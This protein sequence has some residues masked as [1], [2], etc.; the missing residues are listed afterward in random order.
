[1][2]AMVVKQWLQF[3]TFSL[4]SG[5]PYDYAHRRQYRYNALIVWHV[6]GIVSSLPLLMHLSVVL[7]LIGLVLQLWQINYTV[8][9][10]VLTLIILFLTCYVVTLLLPLIF[11]ACPYK[12]SALLLLQQSWQYSR[13]KLWMFLS[14]AIMVFDNTLKC[15]KMSLAKKHV[16]QKAKKHAYHHS[17]SSQT[18]WENIERHKTALDIDGIMWL[19]RS[20]QKQEV[21]DLALKSIAKLSY[22]SKMIAQMLDHEIPDILIQRAF[23]PLPSEDSYFWKNLN[24]LHPTDDIFQRLSESNTYMKSLITIWRHPQY[25]GPGG[26]PAISVQH[27]KGPSDLLFGQWVSLWQALKKS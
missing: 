13:R 18:E 25:F 6:P 7:F 5:T 1:M 12:S 19:L 22:T 21:V 4:S 17:G 8:A 27:N 2:A 26:L 14:Q 9:S 24:V 3:Y 16:D 10:A 15:D 23:T 20:S 11:S